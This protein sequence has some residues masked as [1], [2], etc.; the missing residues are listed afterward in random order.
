MECEPC[1][2]AFE[3][4]DHDDVTCS[5]CGGKMKVVLSKRD[6]WW[7]QSCAPG[8]L[9]D[10]E[11]NGPFDDEATALECATEGLDE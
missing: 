9:P 7:W 6:T 1:G 11:P 2:M 8:C 10:S 4:P 5:D 3:T